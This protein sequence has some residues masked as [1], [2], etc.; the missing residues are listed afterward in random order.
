[1]G[2][3]TKPNYAALALIVLLSKKESFVV[4]LP[5]PSFENIYDNWASANKGQLPLLH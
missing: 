5:S 3:I 4:K 2:T 1:M